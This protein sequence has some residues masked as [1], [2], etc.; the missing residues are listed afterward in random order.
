MNVNMTDSVDAYAIARAENGE[1]GA[2]FICC[3]VMLYIVYNRVQTSSEGGSWI[4]LSASS[5]VVSVGI[6]SVGRPLCNS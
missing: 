2:M 3:V 4:Q 5:R 6:A 1:I